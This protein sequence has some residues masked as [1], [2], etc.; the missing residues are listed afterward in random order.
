MAVYVLNKVFTSYNLAV[1]DKEQN[2]FYAFW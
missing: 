1:T 2:L